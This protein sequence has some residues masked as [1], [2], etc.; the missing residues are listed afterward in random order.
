MTIL[1]ITGGIGSG[2]SYVARLLHVHWNIP[3]Y[4]CDAAA[5]RLEEEDP[6]LRQALIAAVGPEVYD[7]EIG[8]LVRPVLARYLFS[9]EA[10][11]STVNAIVHPAVQRDFQRWA[12]CQRD[13]LLAVESAILYESGFDSLVDLVLYVDAPLDVR[14][15][16]AMRRDGA[17]LAQVE[18]RIARQDSEQGRSR[19]HY[20]IFNGE[21]ADE[22]ELLRQM[23][24][25][26]KDFLHPLAS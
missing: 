26:L 20:V 17:S 25:A 24:E 11:A 10:H 4:D 14:I 18:A 22:E 1:G 12:E 2:K 21:D 15:R 3:V 16:R 19:A 6:S 8:H 9:S 23:E 7:G 13:G 5:K